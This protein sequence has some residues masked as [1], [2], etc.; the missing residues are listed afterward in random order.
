MRD[1]FRA[2]RHRYAVEPGQEQLQG[3]DQEGAVV[4]SYWMTKRPNSPGGSS[5]SLRRLWCS[6]STTLCWS[7]GSSQL[8]EELVHELA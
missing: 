7:A 8:P 2:D 3:Q 5:M 1:R 4:R 6:K